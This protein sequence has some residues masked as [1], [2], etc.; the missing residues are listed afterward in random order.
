MSYLEWL[1]EY[2]ALI[3]SQA[4]EDGVPSMVLAELQCHHC[5]F[6]MVG[7]GGMMML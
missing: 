6:H 7:S 5:Q 1:Y 3:E 2:D 4:V